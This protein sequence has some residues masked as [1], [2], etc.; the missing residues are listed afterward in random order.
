MAIGDKCFTRYPIPEAEA[1]DP[2][3]SCLVVRKSR[4]LSQSCHCA[5]A[6]EARNFVE[7]IRQAR[8]DA[9]HNCWAFVAGPPASTASIGSSDDG[10]PHGTAGKPILQ[11]LLHSGVGQIC[12][13]V[14]RWFGGIKLGTGGLSRAYQQSALENLITLPTGEM[15]DWKRWKIIAQY[16]H[17]ETIAKALPALEARMENS[18]YGEKA[19]FIVLI[20]EERENELKNFVARASNGTAIIAR[21]KI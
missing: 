2:H 18:A 15:I 1:S 17:A 21:E 3:C 13:V 10:E 14:S 4:F 9:T 20:P 8:P 11:A 7:K 19:E 12:M 5:T 16:A 6:T